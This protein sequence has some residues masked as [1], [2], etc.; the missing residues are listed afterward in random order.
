MPDLI[1][2]ESLRGTHPT[3]T[4]LT[5]FVQTVSVAVCLITVTIYNSA[6]VHILS[7]TGKLKKT[8]RG[9]QGLLLG[10]VGSDR[11]SLVVD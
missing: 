4:R 9:L 5:Y 10:H 1:V 7:L 8:Q 2:D 11:F 6:L 3:T